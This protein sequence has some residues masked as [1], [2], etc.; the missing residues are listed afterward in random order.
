MYWN[1]F[2]KHLILKITLE[3]IL[4]VSFDLGFTIKSKC[5]YL[6]LFSLHFDTSCSGL[7]KPFNRL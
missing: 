4:N 7:E 1:N 3:R 2:N 6:Y 5:L